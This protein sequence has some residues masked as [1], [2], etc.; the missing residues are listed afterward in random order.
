MVRS[1]LMIADWDD[2][3][4][5]PVARPDATFFAP[6]YISCRSVK[7]KDFVYG[8]LKLVVELLHFG[9]LEN[10]VDRIGR[11]SRCEREDE[12]QQ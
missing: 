10:I 11:S 2:E 9:V 5:P 1:R 7:F 4:F 3:S 8:V 12:F 6:V